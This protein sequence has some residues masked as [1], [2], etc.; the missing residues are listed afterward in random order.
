MA[1]GAQIAQ[2]RAETQRLG[3]M[4]LDSA[5]VVTMEGALDESHRMAGVVEDLEALLLIVTKLSL[6]SCLSIPKYLGELP[7][8]DCLLP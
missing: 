8:K 6:N 3:V 2:L 1:E 7:L 4:V 5:S